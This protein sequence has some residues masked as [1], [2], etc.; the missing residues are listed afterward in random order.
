MHV[1]SCLALG[2]RL[3]ETLNATTGRLEVTIVDADSRLT[4][5]ACREHIMAA[6]KYTRLKM[7]HLGK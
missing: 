7:T 6:N 5:V 3:G 1:I 2:E 4:A